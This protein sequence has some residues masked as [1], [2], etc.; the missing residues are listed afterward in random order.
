MT[1]VEDLTKADCPTHMAFYVKFPE[2]VMGNTGALC[3]TLIALCIT[4]A[5]SKSVT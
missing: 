2:E 1:M 5:R 4:F 3:I